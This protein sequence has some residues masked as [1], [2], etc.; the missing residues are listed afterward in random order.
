M[1]Q[2]LILSALQC[3]RR[4][5]G[6]QLCEQTRFPEAKVKQQ[7]ENLIEDGVIERVGTANRPE[8]ILSRRVYI[9]EGRIHAYARQIPKTDLSALV[10][11][12][13]HEKGE[14]SRAEVSELLRLPPQRTYLLLKKMIEAGILQ[15]IGG[16]RN[17]RYVLSAE[18]RTKEKQN[19]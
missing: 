6:E 9:A 5:S 15:A 3:S 11:D 10:V 2:L 7:I 14:V 13:V 16:N 1:L 4:L 18:T 19:Y 12:F 8:F 17:R